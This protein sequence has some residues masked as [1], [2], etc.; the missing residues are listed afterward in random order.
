[1]SYP[2]G[3][4][5]RDA[6]IQA[7]GYVQRRMLIAGVCFMPLALGCVLLW[8]NIDVKGKQQTRGVVF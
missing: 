6:I 8:R 5:A 7:Y 1:M 2:I 3:S 4:V